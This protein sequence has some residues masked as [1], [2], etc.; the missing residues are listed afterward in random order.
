MTFSALDSALVGPL[1]ATDAMRAVFSDTTRLGCMIEAEAALARAEAE[2]GLVPANLAPAI[3]AI[4]AEALDFTSIGARTILAGV[5]SIPFVSDMQKLLPEG[6]EPFFHKGSTSQDIVDTALVLQI[7]AGLELVRADINALLPDLAAMARRYRHSPCVGRSYG[8]HAA[9]ISF[10]YKVA[11]WASG[12][13]EVAANFAGVR[14]RVLTVSL[15]GPVGTLAGL[16]VAGPKVLDDFARALD[17]GADA[18]GWHTRRARL[19]ELAHWLALLLSVL[20]KMAGDI[21]H[22][23]ST[24]VAEVAEPY[25]KGRGGSSAMPHKRNPIGAML[26]LAA[27]S[28]AKGHVMTMLDAM[29]A[30][31]ERPLG[32]WQAEWHALPQLFGLVSGALREACALARG[33]EVDEARM[34]TNIDATHGMLFAD[35][36]AGKLTPVL[37]RGRAHE[38]VEHAANEVRATGK[39]LRE[40]IARLT[41]TQAIEGLDGAFDLAPAVRAA[42]LWTDRALEDLKTSI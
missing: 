1:F 15:A 42:A 27:Q 39:P 34:R 26:I 41:A 19:A 8:Q 35:A 10:G 21:A 20:A 28:V 4:G 9:P 36:V 25:Q 24:E 18:I 7:R 40:I 31:H 12:V 3:S 37:G 30:A 6:L 2:N 17:L 32:P 14:K 29:I 38:L 13:G 5:P 22:L 23:A 16:G 33:L 11:V